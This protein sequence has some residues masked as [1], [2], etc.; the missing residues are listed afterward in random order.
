MANKKTLKDYAFAII[1]ELVGG[2]TEDEVQVESVKGVSLEDLTLDDL[3]HEKIRLEREERKMLDRLEVAENKKRKLFDEG[4][5][6]ASKSEQLSIARRIKQLSSEADSMN[7]MLR[8]ISKQLRI[9]D[10][11][12]LV[13]EKER[14][15][16]DTGVTRMIQ[17]IDL[18]K[19]IVYIDQASVDGEFK[20]DKFDEI[21][22]ALD[23]ADAYS[24]ELSEDQDVL[25]IV[26]AMQSAREAADSPEAL[27]EQYQEFARTLEKQKKTEELESFEEDF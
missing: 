17:D 27:E 6:K 1:R 11:L 12:L 15:L 3:R 19:L 7:Q 18:Q 10:G 24:P 5:Q 21:L 23:E 8:V 22:R 20:L 14:V 16:A 4:V 9:I 26:N 25:A 13:K 2:S